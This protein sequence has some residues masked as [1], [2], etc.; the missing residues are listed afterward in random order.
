MN[1]RTAWHRESDRFLLS[2][3]FF[4]RIPIPA[5]VPYSEDELNQAAIYFPLI[6]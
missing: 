1:E 2:L 5:R 3:Q 4:T 6:G